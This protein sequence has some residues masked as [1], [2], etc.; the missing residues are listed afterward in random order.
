M[1]ETSEANSPTGVRIARAT[2]RQVQEC[3]I[4]PAEGMAIFRRFGLGARPVR[5][6]GETE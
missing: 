1:Q 2:L 4:A 5:K 6:G 3:V